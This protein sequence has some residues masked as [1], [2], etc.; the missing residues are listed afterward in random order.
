[1]PETRI[2]PTALVDPAAELGVGVEVGPGTI[3]EAGARI[4][5]GNWIGPWVHIMGGVEIG[6]D[7]RIFD[8]VTIGFPPQSIGFDE[9][10]P[11]RTVI[12]ARNTIREY[13]NIHRATHE[14]EPTRIGDDCFLMGMSHIAHDCQVG[15]GVIMAN[16]ATLAGHVT[17]GERTFV[18][19]NVA[20][21]Q[22]CRVGRLV[23]VGG[24]AKVTMDVPPF[25]IADGNPA[26]IR[27]LNTV[28]LKRAD[29]PP[30]VRK[31]LKRALRELHRPGVSFSRALAEFPL[32]E[33]GDEV[34]EFVEF[35][36][37]SRRGMTPFTMARGGSA[38]GAAAEPE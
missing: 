10:K 24:L 29:V 15:N 26:R 30:H 14:E 4:G 18:S 28:G 23:M 33:H 27:G 32:H 3:I 2:H 7:N 9:S 6:P 13:G 17:L 20:I 36:R 38:R 5:D 1:M 25:T 12:G 34:R 35:F 31:E 16:N 21:H 37:D 8:H 22:F 11:T 19:G